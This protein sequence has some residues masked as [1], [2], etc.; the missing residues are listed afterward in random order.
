MI[1]LIMKLTSI[2][3]FLSEV[4]P[5]KRKDTLHTFV[6]IILTFLCYW[7]FMSSIPR[8]CAR[9]HSTPGSLQ[10]LMVKFL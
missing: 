1:D 8:V 10:I 6:D 4:L 5:T 2:I 7:L 9:S 3:I